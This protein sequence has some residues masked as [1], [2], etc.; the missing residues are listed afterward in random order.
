QFNCFVLQGIIQIQRIA[1]NQSEEQIRAH[2][3]QTEREMAEIERETI[4]IRAMAEADVRAHEAKLAEDVNRRMLI[5][6]ANKELGKWAAAIH[7]TFNH[8]TIP[9]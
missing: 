6:R 8:T 3:R 1:R 2:R 9:R 5:D 4:R 7:P